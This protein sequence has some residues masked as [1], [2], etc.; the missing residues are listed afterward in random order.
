MGRLSG[1]HSGFNCVQGKKHAVYGHAGE[2]TCNGIDGQLHSAEILVLLSTER[3]I[4]I[5]KCPFFLS[6]NFTLR[7]GA[8]PKSLHLCIEIFIVSAFS[9]RTFC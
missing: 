4:A 7:G 5:K 6:R 1:L 9:I 8:D 3:R 2:A